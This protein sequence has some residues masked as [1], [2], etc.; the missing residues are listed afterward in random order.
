MTRWMAALLVFLAIPGVTCADSLMAGY[1]GMTGIGWVSFSSILLIAIAVCALFA[2]YARRSV[3]AAAKRGAFVVALVVS[4]FGW[5]L[6][7]A[8]LAAAGMFQATATGLFPAAGVGLG[9][10]TVAGVV[11]VVRSAALNAVVHAVPL[12]W[13]VG[14]QFYRVIGGIFLLLYGRGELPGEFAIPAGAGDVLIGLTAPL[15]AYALYRHGGWS[16]HAAAFAWNIAGIADL[17]I[18]V[19]TGFLSSPGPLQMLAFDNPSHLITAF[20]LVLVPLF[21]VPVSIVLHVAALER[22]SHVGPTRDDR[23]G[24]PALDFS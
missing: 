23:A 17:V 13:L 20:P 5:L 18:A 24:A 1:D 22:Q 9:F 7:A 19:G 15:V 4:V 6:F 11:L 16:S 10:A 12:P 3:L 21:A 2:F 8:V 14:I